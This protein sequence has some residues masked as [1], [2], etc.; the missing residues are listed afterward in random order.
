MLPFGNALSFRKRPVSIETQEDFSLLLPSAGRF[1]ECAII[2]F[3]NVKC[4]FYYSDLGLQVWTPSVTLNEEKTKAQRKWP[5][6]SESYIKT[7]ILFLC[8]PIPFTY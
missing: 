7:K 2:V 8:I 6:I 1:L 3:M 5:I 4:F